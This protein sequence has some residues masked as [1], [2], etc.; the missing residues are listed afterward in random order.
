MKESVVAS[1]DIAFLRKIQE[2]AEVALA[3]GIRT[4]LNLGDFESRA[5]SK[6][7]RYAVRISVD[8]V[9]RLLKLAGGLRNG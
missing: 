8:E 4:Q 7:G 5:R 1:E 3:G 9:M 6:A 2:R